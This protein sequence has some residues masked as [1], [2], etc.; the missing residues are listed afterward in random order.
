MEISWSEVADRVWVTTVDPDAANV[1]LIAGDERAMLAD[2]GG[3]PEVGAALLA[4]ARAQVTVP[5]ETVVITHHHADHWH[6]IAGMPDVESMAHESVVDDAP[7]AELRPTTLISV[8]KGIQLGER[9]VEIAHFGKAHTQSDLVV[10]VPS[11]DVIVVGDLVEDEPQFDETTQFNTWPLTLDGVLTS[12]KPSTVVIPGH[13][14]VT[15]RDA[16]IDCSGRIADT[17]TTTSTLVQQGVQLDQ[18]YESAEQWAFSEPTVRQA[19][20][21]LVDELASRGVVARKQLPI[22]GI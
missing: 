8:L 17:F 9:F 18:L 6:G 11:A 5:V 7:P 1:T 3:T 14:P 10:V 13:G 12:S 20:P 22:Q 15:N 4:S 21:L 16:V 2:A 19:L